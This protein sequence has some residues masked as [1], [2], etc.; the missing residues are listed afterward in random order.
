MFLH[1]IPE[2]ITGSRSTYRLLLADQ[3]TPPHK[4]TAATA[5]C[6]LLEFGFIPLMQPQNRCLPVL[7]AFC[8]N[9]ISL[10]HFFFLEHEVY[11]GKD[12]FIFTVVSLADTYHLLGTYPNNGLEAAWHRT[13]SRNHPHFTGEPVTEVSYPD[14]TV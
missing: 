13:W 5:P 7:S 11:E 8:H 10:H 6:A 4:A 2:L 9:L 14:R 3:H 1:E 12:I